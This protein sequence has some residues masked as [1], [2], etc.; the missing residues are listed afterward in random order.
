MNAA[1]VTALI[2]DDEP[3]LRTDLR[4]QL[5][6]LWPELE[7]VAMCA[8]GE[9]A[10]AACE[11]LHPKIAFLDIRM[12]K[13]DGLAVANQLRGRA[14]VVFLTAYENHALQAFGRAA[15]DY[16][17][18]PIRP[19]RLGD[20]VDRLKRLAGSA[21]VVQRLRVSVGRVTKWLPIEDVLYFASEAGDTRVVTADAEY[22]IRA[23]L[24]AL[25]R[26]YAP[27]FQRV[28]RATLVQRAKIAAVR[29]GPC[30]E[31]MVELLDGSTLAVS[32]AN[33]RGFRSN[34]R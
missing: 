19:E 11:R 30:N 32:R 8:D 23:S 3:L 20:T 16:V 24:D 15:V 7:I 5:A 29:R 34:L 33:R 9:Q 12:P 21:L 14:H 17:L 22:F 27:R 6:E 13:L 28:H 1:R 2:A 26:D 31:M 18:K 4:A 25:A 10:L